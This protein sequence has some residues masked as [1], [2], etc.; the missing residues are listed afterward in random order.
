M[1]NS[2]RKIVILYSLFSLVIIAMVAIAVYSGGLRNNGEDDGNGKLP[3]DVQTS[4]LSTSIPK[5]PNAIYSPYDKVDFNSFKQYEMNALGGE[6]ISV[7]EYVVRGVCGYDIDK[8]TISTKDLNGFLRDIKEWGL[9][10]SAS[11]ITAVGM[12]ADNLS[13]FTKNKNIVSVELVSLE[14]TSETKEMPNEEK[15][16]T[17]LMVWDNILTITM[18]QRFVFGM[19]ENI[20]ILAPDETK[21]SLKDSIERGWYF[22]YE[23]NKEK[24]PV[25]NSISVIYNTIKIE[26]EDFTRIEWITENGWIAGYG[27]EINPYAMNIPQWN[28]DLG[29]IRRPNKYL[30]A[31]IVGKDG[32]IYTQPIGFK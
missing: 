11:N 6:R 4:F 10:F 31:V 3:S 8:P 16:T 1:Q 27:E 25:V 18:P 24:L 32:V 13:E 12:A 14:V 9:Y 5:N 17:S 22:S 7:E 23:G 26:A 15:G 28:S 29:T 19:T 2:K 20:I 21:E 30:R